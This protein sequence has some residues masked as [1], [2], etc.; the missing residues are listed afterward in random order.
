MT[1]QT[2]NSIDG[3]KE[4]IYSVY[5]AIFKTN[6]DLWRKNIL[7]TSL[8]GGYDSSWKVIGVSENAVNALE[9]YE[10]RKTSKRGVTRAHI[11]QRLDVTKKLFGKKLGFDAFFEVFN[12]DYTVLVGKGENTTVLN[13][14]LK[15]F[16]IDL[17][18]D[19]FL[20][21]RIGF[22][23][24]KNER[25]WLNNEKGEAVPLKN[26]IALID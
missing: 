18:E 4:D 26:I 21:A 6:L 17:K 1:K 8:V 25:D 13:E 10:K 22:R 23:Y 9:D 11:V 20:C 2:S 5:E 15:I 7:L 19:L 12:S 14:H 16:R 24:G 3:D